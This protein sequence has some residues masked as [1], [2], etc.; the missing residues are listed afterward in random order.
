[1]YVLEV[2]TESVKLSY[3][4]GGWTLRLSK[5]LEALAL[6]LAAFCHR[7]LAIPEQASYAIRSLLLYRHFLYRRSEFNTYEYLHSV[8]SFPLPAY[9][10]GRTYARNEYARYSLMTKEHFGVRIYVMQK[11]CSLLPSVRHTRT[12]SNTQVLQGRRS[13]C[14]SKTLFT[15]RSHGAEK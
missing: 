2:A 13:S 5:L 1:M 12:R 14:V 6:A 7:I 10:A 11:R 8:T 9:L 4:E 15:A 3:T